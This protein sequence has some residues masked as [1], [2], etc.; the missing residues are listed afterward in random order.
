MA[1]DIGQRVTSSFTGAGTI[2]GELTKTE[3]K[4]ESG[5]VSITGYQAVIFDNPTLGEKVWEVR[6]LNPL[7]E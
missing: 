5:K 2:T 6:K 1:F 7:D 4:D 3:D